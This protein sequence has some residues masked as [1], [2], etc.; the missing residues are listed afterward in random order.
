[1]LLFLKKCSQH[2]AAFG[3]FISHA[4]VQFLNKVTRICV[5][6]SLGVAE[7]KVLV[8]DYK[9]APE[10]ATLIEFCDL[11]EVFILNTIYIFVNVSYLNIS[12][13][14]STVPITSTRPIIEM[15]SFIYVF[16]S[17]CSL[18]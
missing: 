17:P 14:I 2:L 6:Q 5:S 3:G 12:I 15:V 1:M 18:S 13:I 8:H 16:I 7:E 9:S 11:N 4:Q 10:Y